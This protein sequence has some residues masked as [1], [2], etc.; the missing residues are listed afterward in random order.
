MHEL[1]LHGVVKVALD[2]LGRLITRRNEPVV[3][4]H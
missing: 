2:V 4:L 1:A 3:K